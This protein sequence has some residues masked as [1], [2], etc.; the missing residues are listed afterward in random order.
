VRIDL[1]VVTNVSGDDHL[2]F[3]P[4]SEDDLDAL[5]AALARRVDN[6]WKRFRDAAHELVALHDVDVD[7]L[8]AAVRAIDVTEAAGQPSP[9]GDD[10]RGPRRSRA[11]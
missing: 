10:R 2:R 8:V 5:R 9:E 4:V 6:C 11:E 7:K 3:T 1:E